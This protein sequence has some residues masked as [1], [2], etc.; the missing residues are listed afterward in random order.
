MSPASARSPGRGSRQR[1]C[2]RRR[3]RRDRRVRPSKSRAVPATKENSPPAGEGP[4]RGRRPPLAPAEAGRPRRPAMTDGPTAAADRR[5]RRSRGRT[6]RLAVP[7]ASPR[8]RGTTRPRVRLAGSTSMVV[9]E[10]PGASSRRPRRRRPSTRRPAR[11]PTASPSGRTL[12]VRAVDPNQPV[13]SMPPGV[14][15]L[16]EAQGGAAGADRLPLPDQPGDGLAALRRPAADRGRGPG[17]R[18]G[19]RGPAHARPASSGSPR[20]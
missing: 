19:G 5:P 13:E 2:R 9:G 16:A 17:Q 14:G 11:Q 3:R 8:R 1:P 12:I 15:P 4:G 6:R 10:A 18:L 20:S 7:T